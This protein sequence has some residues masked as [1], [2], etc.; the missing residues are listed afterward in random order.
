MTNNSRLT[1]IECGE[2]HQVLAEIWPSDSE[3]A[4][5]ERL[6]AVESFDGAERIARAYRENG[7]PWARGVLDC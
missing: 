2:L 7:E 4:E 1:C 3:P 5:A 6:A